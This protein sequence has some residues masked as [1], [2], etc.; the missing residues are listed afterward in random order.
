MDEFHH[1]ILA[2]LKQQQE[3]PEQR[4]KPGPLQCQCSALPVELSGNWE[5][6]VMWIDYKPVDVEI[7][8]DYTA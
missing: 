3:R 4:F 1:C 2:L 8:D 5:L 7:D 6:V